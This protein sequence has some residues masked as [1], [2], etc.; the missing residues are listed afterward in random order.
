[1]RYHE[2][3]GAGSW[4]AAVGLSLLYVAAGALL[5][6]ASRVQFIRNRLPLEGTGPS[7]KQMETGFFKIMVTGVSESEGERVRAVASIQDL[8]R[9]GGYL[10]TSRMLLEV[11][12]CMALQADDIKKDPY[13]GKVAG[14]VLTPASATGLVLVERLKAAGYNLDVHTE[15]PV[16]KKT[17]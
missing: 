5:F 15:T 4:L 16:V 11:A 12:L 9:D 8:H 14:G 1:M 2:F 10:S 7:R 13:A 3:M 6:I 17:Q